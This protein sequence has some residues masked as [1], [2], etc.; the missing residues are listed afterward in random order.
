MTD[1]G[2]VLMFIIVV[3]F[4]FGRTVLLLVSV[5]KVVAGVVYEIDVF[6]V[7]LSLLVFYCVCDCFK[8]LTFQQYFFNM[9]LYV[10]GQN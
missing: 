8:K 4:F 9:A 1:A 3:V 7:M 5:V 10:S 2:D 6:A